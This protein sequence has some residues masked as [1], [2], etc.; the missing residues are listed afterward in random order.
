LLSMLCL[1]VSVLP[2]GSFM[3]LQLILLS[4]KVYFSVLLSL[5]LVLYIFRY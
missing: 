1:R 3:L 4:N 2:D 5:I